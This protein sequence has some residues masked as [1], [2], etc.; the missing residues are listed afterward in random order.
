MT[1]PQDS[2]AATNIAVK[3][4]SEFHS[5]LKGANSI[6]EIHALP[7]QLGSRTLRYEIVGPSE[8]SVAGCGHELADYLDKIA[9]LGLGF[10]TLATAATAKSRHPTSEGGR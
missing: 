6:T 9:S 1:L 8:R 3:Q 4:A 7:A 5:E 10:Y 2:Q